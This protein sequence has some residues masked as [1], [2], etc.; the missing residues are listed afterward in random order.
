[1]VATNLSDAKEGAKVWLRQTCLNQL[2]A[3]EK[4]EMQLGKPESQK[5]AQ[6]ELQKWKW[7][8]SLLI[9]HKISRIPRYMEC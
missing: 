5:P 6:W 7:V 1:M 8:I 4:A 2:H 9:T 3:A